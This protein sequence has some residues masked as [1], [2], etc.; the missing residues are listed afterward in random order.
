MK[1]KQ[2]VQIFKLEERVLFDGAAAAEIAA[3][4]DQ[5]GE[6]NQNQ[7]QDDDHSDNSEQDKE[8]ELIQKTVQNA[9]PVDTPEPDATVQNAGEGLPQA[10]AAQNDPAEVLINGHAD[11]TQVTDPN[12][13]FSGDVAEFIQTAD[14]DAAAE[15]ADHELIVIDSEAVD[16]FDQDAFEGKNVLFLD[17]DS[18]AADQIEDW[19][20]DHSDQD[21]SEVRLVT[22]SDTLASQVSDIDNLEVSTVNAFQAELAD[23]D[24]SNLVI[25]PD[26]EANITVDAPADELPEELSNDVA[27]GRHEL[28]ILNSTTADIDNVLEQLGDSRDVLIIDSNADA[29]EQISDYLDN[30][31]TSYDAVHILTHGSDSG[32]VLGSEFISDANDF[33][34]FSDHIA[35]DGDLMLYGCNMASSESGQAFLQGIADASGADVAASTDTTGSAE[36]NGNWNLEYS[37]GEINADSITLD[38]T[39]GHRLTNYTVDGTGGSATKYADLSTL[40]GSV[41]LQNNDVITFAVDDASYTSAWNI[42]TDITINSSA[43]A[44]LTLA[45]GLNLNGASLSVSGMTIEGNVT[46]AND[47]TFVMDDNSSIDGLAI[48]NGTLNVSGATSISDVQLSDTSAFNYADD[49]SLSGNVVSDIDLSFGKFTVDGTLTMGNGTTLTLNSDQAVISGTVTMEDGSTLDVTDAA[50]ITGTVT[51]EDG[52]TLNLNSSATIDTIVLESTSTFNYTSGVELT[53]SID[54]HIDLQFDDP[55]TISGTLTMEGGTALALNTDVTI[56]TV[57]LNENSEFTY[58]GGVTLTG[59][60]DSYIDVTLADPITITGNLTME[61]GTALAL[62]ADVSIDTV[63]L[64]TDTAF[65]YTG[66]V[67][68]TGNIDSY[69]DITLADP[70]TVT[71]TLTMESGTALAQEADVHIGTVELKSDTSFSY[72]AGVTLYGGIDTS[73]DLTF[74][75]AGAFTIRP[76]DDDTETSAITLRAGAMT[77]NTGSTLNLIDTAVTVVNGSS[78]TTAVIN[79]GTLNFYGDNSI[80]FQNGLSEVYSGVTNTGTVNIVKDT[81]IADTAALTVNFSLLATWFQKNGL[82]NNGANAV[83]NITEGSLRVNTSANTSQQVYAINNMQGKTSDGGGVVITKGS[84]VTLS[85]RGQGGAA[86]YNPKDQVVTI[87]TDG[88][89]DGS[90]IEM[91]SLSGNEN[92]A[93]Y[94][95][96]TLKIYNSYVEASGT[97]SIGLFNGTDGTVTFKVDVTP[98]AYLTADDIASLAGST[99]LVGD[100]SKLV[101]SITGSAYSVYNQ[102]NFTAAIPALTYSGTIAGTSVEDIPV[103][104]LNGNVGNYTPASGK[105]PTLNLTNIT[106]NGDF[107]QSG[108][109]KVLFTDVVLNG[110]LTN[111]IGNVFI[112]GYFGHSGK[113]V[114]GTASQ[115]GLTS[116]LTVTN[117]GNLG[118][119][120]NIY[121]GTTLDQYGKPIPGQV[122]FNPGHRY[123]FKNNAG[124]ME[125][126]NFTGLSSEDYPVGIINYGEFFMDSDPDPESTTAYD[127]YVTGAYPTDLLVA[128]GITD[129][130]IFNRNPNGYNET[131]EIPHQMVLTDLNIRNTNAKSAAVTNYGGE[132]T[133]TRGSLQGSYSGIDTLVDLWKVSSGTHS[134]NYYVTTP[135]TTLTDLTKIAGRAYSIRNSGDLT[136]TAD[137]VNV[138]GGTLLTATPDFSVSY[139][140]SYVAVG[141]FTFSLYINEYYTS[142]TSP[143]ADPNDIYI[144]GY[145]GIQQYAYHYSATQSASSLVPTLL[146]FYTMSAADTNSR[147]EITLTV[148]DTYTRPSGSLTLTDW[149]YGNYPVLAS[150]TV[151]NVAFQAVAS[152]SVNTAILNWGSLTITGINADPD[153]RFTG[154]SR[155]IDNGYTHFWADDFAVIYAATQGWHNPAFSGSP[156]TIN[157]HF[158]P[159][160]DYTI[161]FDL[162]GSSI[163]TSSVYKGSM[164]L[165]A[166]E[167]PAASGMYIGGLMIDG[168]RYVVYLTQTLTLENFSVT[169]TD[170]D[171]I[172]NAGTLLIFNGTGSETTGWTGPS[173]AVITATGHAGIV[174]KGRVRMINGVIKDSQTAIKQEASGLLSVINSTLY[175]NTAAI[176]SSLGAPSSGGMNFEVIDTTI[177]SKNDD[178]IGIQFNAK[179]Q[180]DLVNSVILV[181]GGK[182]L[183]N[184]I[185]ATVDE[186]DSV[187]IYGNGEEDTNTKMTAVYGT[188]FDGIDAS[189]DP[190]LNVLY[191]A[192]GSTALSGGVAVGYTVSDGVYEFLFGGD[193]S[194]AAVKVTKDKGGNERGNAVG[195]YVLTGTP[196]PTVPIIVNTVKDGDANPDDKQYS[197][198]YVLDYLMSGDNTSKTTTVEFAWDALKAE[199]E[200]AGAEQLLFIV[201]SGTLAISGDNDAQ[202]TEI[203]IDVSGNTTGLAIT[204]GT[205]QTAE[206]LFTI[207]GMKVTLTGADADTFTINGSGNADASVGVDG[208]AFNLVEAEAEA[209]A[210]AEV[211]TSLILSNLTV[212]GGD[213]TGNGG[214]VY[215]GGANVSLTADG[216]T[217]SGNTAANGGAIYNDGGTVTL[218]TA[219]SA[220]TLS[221]NR[222]A[223]GGAVYMADG[224]LT[225]IGNLTDNI[226]SGDGGAIYM[227]DGTAKVTGNITG[228]AENTAAVRGG[229]VYMADGELTVIGNLTDNTASGDGG[230]IYNL[231]GTVTL[232]TADSAVTLS[233]NRGAN[234]GAVYMADGEL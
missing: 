175:N 227:L 193:A 194:S 212:T 115:A 224:E 99:D 220:V 223:N 142:N 158:A 60:V 19:L 157:S 67:T 147:T 135:K 32:I 68:L 119:F 146:H 109:S 20:N 111:T 229:A 152:T 64:E 83:I 31:D 80:R 86:I 27:E 97:N 63:L 39:W 210:E 114:V 1:K 82:L 95:N 105:P 202:I 30:S 211:K 195:S 22:D 122:T 131:Y 168:G 173:N 233:A 13:D 221:A 8:Q 196:T 78:A 53:G 21:I 219:D 50:T 43:N 45:G 35:A 139:S 7:N 144:Y 110:N 180:L 120:G 184:D 189:Y 66:G 209:E 47:S 52:S 112:T 79:N 155:S 214:A 218:G 91:T 167:D 160:G 58:T 170:S 77:V 222:G 89:V 15:A 44:T 137:D 188:G 140:G 65:A 75:Q 174:N 228:T 38:A 6:Q 25:V 98:D 42:T 213:T 106:I 169:A 117:N 11:F 37:I 208:A 76:F 81:T 190:N 154:F 29:F 199:A 113:I 14:P 2:K 74:D 24:S 16:Q 69:T 181:K 216:T 118:T 55:I 87:G 185:G 171:A 36:F 186:H 145:S 226:A 41:T 133:I 90:R 123:F 34:I 187:N 179:G 198:R 153:Y 204:I 96:G 84:T 70:I 4:V 172:F 162:P 61:S 57:V 71:G 232:G 126:Y 203:T 125:I 191:L 138:P 134:W 107:E 104:A 101:Y 46:V 148:A 128:D 48:I 121:I 40:L 18:D 127:L 164:T 143:A 102:K 92:F 141:N 23:A 3:A 206:S 9:G 103:A 124:T 231:G 130:G 159:D 85:T 182:G 54:S 163:Y 230:A 177:V 156:T 207:T 88:A 192:P 17:G 176:V 136:M 161:G 215:L 62:N 5:A 49:A 151:S 197:L 166:V 183:V 73:I 93:V 100:V 178:S 94:N 10:D 33:S 116:D 149:H 59:S 234:G 150:A 200:A 201:D 56:G 129:T 108:N 165:R 205:D 51:M 225:V 132:L 26:H 28:V 72:T 217:F 12:A